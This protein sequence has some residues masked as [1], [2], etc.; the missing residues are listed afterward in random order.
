MFGANQNTKEILITGLSALPHYKIKSAGAWGA[1]VTVTNVDFIGFKQEATRC[2]RTQHIFHNSKYASDYIPL[3]K[4]VGSTFRDV[5]ND[6]FV[7][8]DEPLEKWAAVDDC[9]EWPCTAPENIVLQFDGNSFSGVRPDGLS[10]DG[11]VTYALNGDAPY[12]PNCIDKT[13]WNAWS[14]SNQNIGVLLFESLDGDTWD[15]SVQPIYITE[16]G[17]A[18]SN[19]LNSMMDHVWDGFYTGQTRLSRFPAQIGTG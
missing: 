19:K 14:C 1:D 9:G 10:T 5:A 2:G 12:Y 15:R 18:Y 13:E 8:F 4:F 11:T 16:D 7:K 17:G 6:A 3:H